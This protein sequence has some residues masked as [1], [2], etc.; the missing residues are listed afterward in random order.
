MELTKTYHPNDY[1]STIYAMWETA[2]AF[3]PKGEGESYSIVM[4]PPNANGDLHIGHALTIALED[5][6]ARYYRMQGRPTVYIPGADHAG[7]ETWVVYERELNKRGQSRTDFS[8]EELYQQV[9]DFVAQ[10]RGDMELQLRALGASCSWD[11]LVFTLDGKVIKTVYATFEKLWKEGLV[12][13]GERIVNYSTKYQTSYA[14]IEVE[15]KEVQGKLYQIAY[16]IL[17][18]VGELVIATTRPE[19]LLGDVAIAVNPSDERYQKWIG[20]TAIV[21]IVNREIPIIADDYVDPAYGTGVLKITPAHDPNDFEV[22]QRHQLTPIQVIGFDGKMTNVPDSFMGLEPQAAREKILKVLAGNDQLRGEEDITHVVGFDY[23]SGLPIE[24]LIKD[25]WFLKIRP[26]AERAKQAIL[27]GEIKFHPESKKRIVINYLDKLHD[28]NLS[29]QIAWGIPIPAFVNVKDKSDWIFD[30]RVNEEFIEIDG[31][32][33]RREEDTFDTWFSSGQWPFITTDYLN[34][35]ELSQFYPTSVMETGVDLLDRWVARMIMLGLYAT[36]QV[37]FREVYMHGM[38][39][40]E[41]SQKMSK[42][43]GNVIS[44]MEVINQYGSDALRFGIV[45][46]RSAGQNQAF[47]TAKVIAGRN[48]CNK[49]WNIS[50]FV[51]SVVP[52]NFVPQIAEQI[53]LES[54]ADHWIISELNQAI[55][56][57]QEHIKNYRFAEAADLIYHTIWSNVADWYVEVSKKQPNPQV[58]VFALETCL[59]MAHP[60]LPFITEVIWQSL[61]WRKGLIINENYPAIETVSYQPEKVQSFEA[62]TKLVAEIRL[63]LKE[64]PAKKGGWRLVYSDDVLLEKN[65]STIAHLG[66]VSAVVEGQVKTGIRLASS[67]RQAWIEVDQATL[68][69]YQ[70]NLETRLLEA[71]ANA[72]KLTERLSNDKYITKA[73]AHLVAETKQQLIGAQAIIKQLETELT[74]F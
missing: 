51:Q 25:Q 48:L 53:A 30:T 69:E 19:T 21:P 4:P 44:P 27:A 45:S 56:D 41:H 28:W 65:G 68:Y 34:N 3:R 26:L 61:E 15:Y 17:D 46:N 74:N 37:P 10:K 64:L 9:W 29:R 70:A 43:K 40:D 58:L 49:L 36:D 12:Y 60:F 14:D 67:D 39:L 71:R 59:K 33:Y 11:H 13:R 32:T 47:S 38:V 50:R 20:K 24:P 7:F 6:L 2:R 57:L 54:E 1:E 35:G 52:D 66:G 18:E 16:Q 55:K 23:K 5:I 62:I 42:S 22:G 63:V 72:A 73:P 8:R 31:K